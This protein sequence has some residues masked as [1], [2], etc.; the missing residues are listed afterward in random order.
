MEKGLTG[1]NT[2]IGSLVTPGDTGMKRLENTWNL[3]RRGVCGWGRRV[4]RGETG[5]EKN[6]GEE[7]E[8]L[9]KEERGHPHNTRTLD[10]KN[11]DARK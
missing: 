2:N 8:G 7:K 6:V 3:G 1:G 9:K 11:G 10:R 4:D 5:R